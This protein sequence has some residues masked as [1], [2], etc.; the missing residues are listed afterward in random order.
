RQGEGGPD[1]EALAGR[2]QADAAQQQAE[3]AGRA[4]VL[5]PVALGEAVGEQ[6]GRLAEEAVEGPA[7]GDRVGHQLGVQVLV[8]GEADGRTAAGHGPPPSLDGFTQGG[9]WP[10]P[11]HRHSG[12]SFTSEHPPPTPGR[13][14]K[15]SYRYRSQARAE[16][17][18]CRRALP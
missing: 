1:G 17:K 8:E 2:L 3:L 9:S 16:I 13:S 18:G 6:L 7:E 5:Q 4:A 10:V 14:G 12:R 15:K 11:R